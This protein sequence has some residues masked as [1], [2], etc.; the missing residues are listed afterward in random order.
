MIIIL[1]YIVNDN[2]YHYSQ[3]VN[4]EKKLSECEAFT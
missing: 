1:L 2:D 4:Y 3:D